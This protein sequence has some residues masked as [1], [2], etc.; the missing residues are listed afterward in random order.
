MA[1]YGH[2]WEKNS[3]KEL[4]WAQKEVFLVYIGREKSLRNARNRAIIVKKYRISEK[5]SPKW[6]IFWTFREN[7]GPKYQ[8]LEDFLSMGGRPKYYQFIH[9]LP[10]LWQIWMIN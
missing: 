6:A 9:N 10:L 5:Y 3:R 1:I 7:Y 4:I 8:K 2:I